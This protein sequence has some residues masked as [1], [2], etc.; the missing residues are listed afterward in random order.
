MTRKDK[1]PADETSRHVIV[2]GSPD[3]NE[4]GEEE[5]AI[6]RGVLRQAGIKPTKEIV[7]RLIGS[8]QANMAAFRQA[9][10]QITR[11]ERHDALRELLHMVEEEDPPVAVIRKRIAELPAFDIAEAEERAH[12]LWSRVFRGESL[13]C[14]LSFVAWS[15][16]AS[17]A[18][19]QE[20]VRTFFSDGGTVVRGRVRPGGKRS[21]SRLE[22]H[23]LGH[24]RGA[25]WPSRAKSEVPAGRRGG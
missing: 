10:S 19:L 18:Q 5:R 25:A 1:P 22:P 24:A 2:A 12:R 17:V 13:E 21:K 16:T 6:L 8:V 11:R 23:I 9:A 7:G 14:G 20:A 4:L 3:Q 15:Q